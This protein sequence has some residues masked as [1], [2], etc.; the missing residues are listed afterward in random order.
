MS[1][2]YNQQSLTFYTVNGQM[3]P[4]EGPRAVPLLLDFS[5]TQEYDLNLQNMQSRNFLSMVQSV[6]VD[7]SNNASPLSIAFPN[8]GQTIKLAPGRQGYFVVLCP[9]PS[10]VS[11]I[12][13]GGV[14]VTVFLL[15]Y[16]VTN[17]DW[18][19]YTGA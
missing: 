7:N 2:A 19:S 9:N 13:A 15:N 4:P 5:Q 16:P 8:T 14:V 10:S 6:F 11:F 12:S 3:L 1:L 17:H 18:P